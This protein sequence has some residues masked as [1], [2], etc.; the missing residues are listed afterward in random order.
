MNKLGSFQVSIV[1]HAFGRPVYV[2]AESFK[3][4]RLFPLSQRDSSLDVVRARAQVRYS[5]L[6]LS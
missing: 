1:A 4:T 3:F 6:P 5:T 2:A